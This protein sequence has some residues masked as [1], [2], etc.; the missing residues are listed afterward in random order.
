MITVEQGLELLKTAG[1]PVAGTEITELKRALNRVLA[2]DV[3]SPL[4]MPPFPQ[5]AMDGYAVNYSDSISVYNNIGEIAAGDNSNVNLEPGEAIRIFTGAM[6]P[7]SANMVIRQEDVDHMEGAL[8]FNAIPDMGANIRPEGEQI[9]AEELALPKGTRLNSAAI[10]FLAGLGITDVEVYKLP[11]V[12]VVSTGNELVEPG[13]RLKPGE[14]YESNGQML[15]AVLNRFGWPDVQ[16]HYIKDSYE[17]TVVK[18]KDLIDSYDLVIFSGGISVGDYDFVGK[19]L[20]DNG[21]EQLFYKIRQKPG[22]PIFYGKYQKNSVFALPGNPAA[23]LTCFLHLCLAFVTLY[24]G[25]GVY[26]FTKD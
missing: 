9:K 11:R 19:A 18:V 1:T 16:C 20:K 22:K 15:A 24:P 4:Q 2:K 23:C 13:T 21:V 5:S 12:A 17:R 25:T 14:I 10:G 6:V 26:W 8:V 3:L 7:P